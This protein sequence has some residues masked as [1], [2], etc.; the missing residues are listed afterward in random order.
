MKLIAQ[1][2]LN[3]TPEQ[4]AA[5]LTTLG[6]AN[7]ACDAISTIA[8][9]AREFRRIPFRSAPTIRL[10]PHSGLERNCSFAVLQR[11]QTPTSWIEMFSAPSARTV[12]SPLMTATYPGTQTNRPSRSGQLRGGSTF[13][14]AW[15]SISANCC[16]TAGARAIWSTTRGRSTCWP[17]ATCRSRTSSRWTEYL[18]S[19]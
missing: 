17:S 5:L 15:A 4:H 19:T 7:A 9:Q 16:R 13:P 6:Q 10:K 1:I 18:G 2:R 12:P 14:T 3:S 11:L 8:W